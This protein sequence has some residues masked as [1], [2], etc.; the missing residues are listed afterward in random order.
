MSVSYTHLDVYKRQEFNLPEVQ[1][2][3]SC[4]NIL[5]KEELAVDEYGVSNIIKKEMSVEEVKCISSALK[6][7]FISSELD[8][9]LSQQEC[10]V[11][12]DE[13]IIAE[14][15]HEELTDEVGLFYTQKYSTSIH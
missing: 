4:I 14:P 1:H 15:E 5:I 3:S 13:L 6:K 12:K 11:I 9:V 2:T 8:P 7:E 10:T